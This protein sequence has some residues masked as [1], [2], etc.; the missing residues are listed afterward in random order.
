M[1]S[2]SRFKVLHLGCPPSYSRPNYNSLSSPL[3]KVLHTQKA[4]LALDMVWLCH[5]YSPITSG[6]WWIHS[7]ISQHS[8]IKDTS[9]ALYES[10]TFC[11]HSH[12]IKP[13]SVSRS[14]HL[15]PYLSAWW[16][17]GSS[18]DLLVPGSLSL[19]WAPV[20]PYLCRRPSNVSR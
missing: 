17:L 12:Y 16:P 20:A 5:C 15:F 2:T 10:W 8:Y 19:P 6:T 3:F 1:S 14:Y 11:L 7:N 9:P 4:E 18:L 13:L